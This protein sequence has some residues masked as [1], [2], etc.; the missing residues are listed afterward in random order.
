MNSIPI[1]ASLIALSNAE[2]RRFLSVS[3]LEIVVLELSL[4]TSGVDISYE[5]ERKTN[6]KHS[7]E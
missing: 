3:I 5:N 7:K 4:F 6:G 2:K 1:D